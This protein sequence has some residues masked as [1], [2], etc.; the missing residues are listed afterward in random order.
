MRPLLLALLCCS[1]T[2]ALRVM[3]IDKVADLM[4]YSGRMA[5]GE[6]MLW[7]QVFCLGVEGTECFEEPLVVHCR[8]HDDDWDCIAMLHEGMVFKDVYPVCAPAG[9]GLVDADACT[10]MYT[11][12][13]K[14]PHHQPQSELT[15]VE[16][17]A[18]SSV[19]MWMLV[20]ICLCHSAPK[21]V[22]AVKAEV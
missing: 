6:H 18:I 4:F 8:K 12:R 17:L 13:W 16:A 20:L 3:P 15:Q 22:V 9:D 2:A 5:A 1:L 19:F 11:L 14:C 21:V 10:L 7:P